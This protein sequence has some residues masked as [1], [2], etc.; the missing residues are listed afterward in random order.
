[1]LALDWIEDNCIASSRPLIITDSQSLCLAIRGFDPDL[2]PIR[3]R[4]VKCQASVGIQWVPG[5]C[6]IPGNE[7]ADTAANEARNITGPHR[8]TS[9]NG[10][11]PSIKYN[12]PP[13]PSPVHLPTRDVL[14]NVKSQGET[15]L[16]QE[17]RHVLGK[18]SLRPPLGP[19][20]L[21]K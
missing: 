7:L 14:Q 9:F 3:A 18:T 4:L 10:I 21:P 19:P 5:H 12:R 1:M 20:H 15:N 8:P 13:L 16:N 6:G 11:I 2:A 17:G